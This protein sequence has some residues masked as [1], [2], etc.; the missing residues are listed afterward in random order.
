MNVF[1][2]LMLESNDI[3]ALVKQ[4]LPQAVYM[5]SRTEAEMLE[6]VKE[7]YERSNQNA[8]VKADTCINGYGR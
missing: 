7:W 5:P 3:M 4:R 1:H 6:S 2:L 8:S